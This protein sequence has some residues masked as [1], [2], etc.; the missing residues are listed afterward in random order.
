MLV[1]VQPDLGSD[2][3]LGL[4]PLELLR[5]IIESTVT[6]SFHSTTYDE[7]QRTLCSL[8]L[9]SRQF[10]AIAQPLLNAVI[11]IEDPR[12]LDSLRSDEGDRTSGRRD[13]IRWLVM[14]RSISRL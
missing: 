11:W 3:M 2:K 8:S 4:L 5:E 7:R 6:H 12:Q 14:D 9:V 10:C 1:V 13:R